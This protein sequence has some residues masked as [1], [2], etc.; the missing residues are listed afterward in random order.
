MQRCR[1][2][3]ARGGRWVALRCRYGSIVAFGDVALAR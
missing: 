1:G 3:G 2:V